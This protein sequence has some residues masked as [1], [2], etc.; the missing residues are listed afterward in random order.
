MNLFSSFSKKSAGLAL[1]AVLAMAG[2]SSAQAVT[3][4]A[5]A[6]ATAFE[7]SGIGGNYL[8]DTSG[9][10]QITSMNATTMVVSFTLKNGTTL[11]GGAPVNP[12]SDARLVS[13]G[14]GIDPNITGI[15]GFNSV[16]GSGM[17][18]AVKTT[19]QGSTNIPSLTG[20]EVCAFGGVSCAG[21]R[22][23]G[24]SAGASDS[25]IIT[26]TGNF[27][28]VR[29]VSFDPLGVKYQTTPNSYE[30][31]CTANGCFDPPAPVPE[32]ASMALLGLGFAAFG[33]TRRRK[34]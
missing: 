27:G 20:I 25:F 22:N 12:T 9:S 34:S 17:L 21:G 26:M 10:I 31:S 7:F 33:L 5:G 14:F 6:P 18:D 8:L 15:A 1:T 28:S 4:T 19:Q 3:I 24:L 16:D 13:F 29:T 2:A 23:G 11:V 32:P 30:Y